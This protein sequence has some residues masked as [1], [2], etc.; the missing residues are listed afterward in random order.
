MN[1]VTTMKVMCIGHAAY[2]ITI[3]MNG[4]LIE[5][6]KNRFLD[7]IES[8][9][10]PACTA[11]YLLGKW[12]VSV[13]FVGTVGNDIYGEKILNEL[14]SVNVDI[15]S[16]QILDSEDTS[17]CFVLINK[18]ASTRTIV[19]FR[20]PDICSRNVDIECNANIVLFDGQEFELTK[21]VLENNPQLISVM[22]AGRYTPSNMELAKKATYVICSKN[23]AEECAK[24]NFDFNAPDSLNRIYM[25]LKK[26][27]PGTVMITLEDKGCMYEDNQKLIIV[28]SIKV[29]SVDT[30]GAGDIFHGA[31]VYTLI[32]NMNIKDALLFSNITAALSTKYIGTRNSIVSKDKVME[33]MNE[34]K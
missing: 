22:D 32:M 26:E 17:S 31:F 21:K 34:I 33:I 14:K 13:S 19:S 5:N 29:D 16:V 12:G 18:D 1:W 7:T 2:D 10:G 9:G 20:N 15:S 11:A 27:I 4:F 30:T 8:G 24:E 6:T 25:A 3:P 28:P 23:F